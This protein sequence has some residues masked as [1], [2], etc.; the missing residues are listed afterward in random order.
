MGCLL[1]LIALPFQVI[2]IFFRIVYLFFKAISEISEAFNHHSRR[3]RRYSR[4]SVISTSP[5]PRPNRATAKAPRYDQHPW[6]AHRTIIGLSIVIFPWYAV[7]VIL[8][9]KRMRTWLRVCV[10]ALLVLWSLFITLS[11][12]A[13]ATAPPIIS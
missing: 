5:H 11:T 13:I 8:V 2:G 6:W 4:P 12:Y 10:V 1:G 3:P 9:R 7:V